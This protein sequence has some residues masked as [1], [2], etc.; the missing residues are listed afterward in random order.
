MPI[1]LSLSLLRSSRDKPEF[2]PGQELANLVFLFFFL[3]RELVGGL[4]PFVRGEAT[5]MGGFASGWWVMVN[6]M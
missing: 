4:V 5:E 3:I 1:F 2:M 6:K